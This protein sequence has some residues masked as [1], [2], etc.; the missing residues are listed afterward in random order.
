MVLLQLLFSVCPAEPDNVPDRLLLD[1]HGADECIIGPE[2]VRHIHIHK[3][4]IQSGGTMEAIVSK[5]SGETP[6]FSKR[7]PAHT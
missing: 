1:M 6:I 7:I 5:P 4:F 3:L 2:K